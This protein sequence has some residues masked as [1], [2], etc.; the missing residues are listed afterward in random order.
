MFESDEHH[1]LLTPV[2]VV[3]EKNISEI[4]SSVATKVQTTLLAKTTLRFWVNET[5]FT[6]IIKNAS[7]DVCTD[8]LNGCTSS[9]IILKNNVWELFIISSH[10]PPIDF[11]REKQLANIKTALLSNMNQ[12]WNIEEIDI[13]SVTDV[14]RKTDDYQKVV[15]LIHELTWIEAE[16]TVSKYNRFDFRRADK[17][18]LGKMNIHIKESW[19]IHFS[20]EWRKV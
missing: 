19:E 8:W 11:M 13:F 5:H 6:K 14:S 18:E 17:E 10:F 15:D 12:I 2:E 1:L 9:I 4:H 7:Y 16:S 3:I 20:H